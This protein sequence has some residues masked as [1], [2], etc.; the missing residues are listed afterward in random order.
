MER[1]AVLVCFEMKKKTKQK[2]SA[3]FDIKNEL[4]SPKFPK[5]QTLDSSLNNFDNRYEDNLRVIFDKWP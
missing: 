5:L 3:D 1:Y 4:E 2:C